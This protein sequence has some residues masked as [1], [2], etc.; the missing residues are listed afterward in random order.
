MSNSNA[1]AHLFG[2]TRCQNGLMGGLVLCQMESVSAQCYC[3]R[4]NRM[5]ACSFGWG[6]A[7]I[8]VTLRQSVNGV[9]AILSSSVSKATL[10]NESRIYFPERYQ[11]LGTPAVLSCLLCHPVTSIITA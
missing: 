1:H 6:K 4:I 2:R 7:I 9:E 5:N 11:L 10:V 8:V 3:R